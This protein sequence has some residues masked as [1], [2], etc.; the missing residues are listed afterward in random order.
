MTEPCIKFIPYWAPKII[1]EKLFIIYLYILVES[2]Y[3]LNRYWGHNSGPEIG[4]VV[5]LLDYLTHLIK[6][7]IA[8]L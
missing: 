8:T 2:K 1:S 5:N 6:V 3:V 4:S 7:V